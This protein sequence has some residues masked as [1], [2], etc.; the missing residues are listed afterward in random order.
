MS[1]KPSIRSTRTIHDGWGT[2]LIA[3]I[4]MPDGS[5]VT[6][7]IEDHGQAVCVLPYDPERRVALLVRQFRAPLFHAD[8]TTELLEAPAGILDEPDPQDGARREAQEETGVRL[9]ALEP[10]A[11][12][13]SMPGISTERM[14][15]FLAPYAEADRVEAGGGLVEEGESMTV[16]E[17]PLE[18]LA[19]MSEAGEITDVKTLL[20][21]YA[22]RLRRPEL[23]R[24]P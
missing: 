22:L 12:V 11:A 18:T 1:A 9:G 3:D 7:E 24:Q 19:A 2:F 16:T 20:M 21:I 5:R 23:F 4:A 6:R 14:H 8:G 15:L 13:W 17:L 10:I